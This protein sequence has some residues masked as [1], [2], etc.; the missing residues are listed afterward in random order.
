M[1]SGPPTG[2]AARTGGACVDEETADD[3]LLARV[4]D[5]D[6]SAM[7]VLYLRHAQSAQR[8]VQSRLRDQFEVSD[9]VQS[10]MLEVWRT[11]GRFQ[12]RS[13]VRS[14]I[15]SIA[16][17]KMID[18]IRKDART[19]LSEPDDTVPDDAPTAEVV[20]ANAQDAARVRACVDELNAQQRAAI[21]LAFFEDLSYGEIAEIENV[22]DGTIKTRVFHAKKLLLRCLSR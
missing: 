1:V 20:I 6:R 14:W 8:F 10:A 11:A 15:L 21:H 3:A 22:P 19:E 12:G 2:G 18:H 17:N 5:G 7:R 16:R 4:A 13:S 9:V